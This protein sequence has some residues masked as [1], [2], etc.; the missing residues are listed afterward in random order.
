M[1]KGAFDVIRAPWYATDVEMAVLR[2]LREE[3]QPAWSQVVA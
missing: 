2:A 1:T 3:E